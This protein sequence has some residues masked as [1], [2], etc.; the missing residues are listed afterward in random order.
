MVSDRGNVKRVAPAFRHPHVGQLKPFLDP[1]TG[2]LKVRLHRL[3]MRPTRPV[4][5][6]VCVA[7]HGPR[8]AKADVRHCD[9]DKFNNAATNLTWGSRRENNLDAV[10]HGTNAN[11]AKQICPRD[12]PLVEPNLV[13][14]TSREGHRNC[15]ACSLG[16]ASVQRGAK[17]GLALDLQEESDA[18]LIRILRRHERQVAD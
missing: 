14:C 8:P 12:H 16:R 11:T 7:F 13:P 18:A 6:L 15:R 10:A 1:T 2:Y 3:G 9:G 17:N 4:H 5:V